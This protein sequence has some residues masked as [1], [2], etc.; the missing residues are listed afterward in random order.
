MAQRVVHGHHSGECEVAAGGEDHF[1]AGLDLHA[2]A[3]AEMHMHMMQRCAHRLTSA[4]KI[5]MHMMPRCA[6]RLTSAAEVR[7]QSGGWSSWSTQ[8]GKGSPHPGTQAGT[9]A[10]KGSPC[11]PV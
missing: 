9:K 7:A 3:A 1:P 10:G 11:Q 4:A 5:H 8:A 6:H 2:P